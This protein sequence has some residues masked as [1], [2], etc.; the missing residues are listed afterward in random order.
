MMDEFSVGGDDFMAFVKK[1]YRKLHSGQKCTAS[2]KRNKKR[3]SD[4]FNGNVYDADSFV[5]LYILMSVF[6]IAFCVYTVH[7]IW[8][9]PTTVDNTVKQIVAFEAGE[10]Y[11]DEYILTS[12]QGE[13]YKILFWDKLENKE[14]IENACD[15]LTELTVYVTEV[16]PHKG[17]AGYWSIKEIQYQN[18]VILSFEETNRLCQENI[19]PLIYFSGGFAVLWGLYIAGSIVVG[20]NPEKYKKYVKLFFKEGYVKY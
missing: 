9:S 10:T 14:A 15:G 2:K 8:F 19:T 17:Q 20:R 12:A 7:R 13:T 1:K 5:F 16:E 18:T 3:N 6:L 4:I 11:D